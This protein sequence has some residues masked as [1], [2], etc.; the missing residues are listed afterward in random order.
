MASKNTVTMKEIPMFLPFNLRKHVDIIIG[1]I[2]TF[3]ALGAVVIPN[4]GTIVT[5]V[6]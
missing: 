4:C 5:P 6:K 3:M 2:L 1:T